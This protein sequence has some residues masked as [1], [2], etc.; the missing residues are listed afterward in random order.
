MTEQKMQ[1]PMLEYSYTGNSL[2]E[3]ITSGYTNLTKEHK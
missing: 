2:S 1:D 3:Y